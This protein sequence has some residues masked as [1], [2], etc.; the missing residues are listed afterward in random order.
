MM[1]NVCFCFKNIQL[2]EIKTICRPNIVFCVLHSVHTVPIA[3]ILSGKNAHSWVSMVAP[4]RLPGFYFFQLFWVLNIYLIL[5]CAAAEAYCYDRGFFF[6]FNRILPRWDQ[7]SGL[8]KK[9][10]KKKNFEKKFW[11]FFFTLGV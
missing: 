3:E 11:I 10:W 6:Y 4:K 9:N 7:N 8:L 2:F 1:F 5:G